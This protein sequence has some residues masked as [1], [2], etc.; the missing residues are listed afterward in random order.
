MKDNNICTMIIFHFSAYSIGES[1]FKS[2]AID[3][4]NI[5]LRHARYVHAKGIQSTALLR[6]VQIAY[7][8]PYLRTTSAMGLVPFAILSQIGWQT[9]N[10]DALRILGLWNIGTGVLLVR[11]IYQNYSLTLASIVLQAPS[12]RWIVRT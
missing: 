6:Y 12:T 8:S 10:T 9:A 3:S 2:N 7:D 4:R 5:I 11:Q 1:E